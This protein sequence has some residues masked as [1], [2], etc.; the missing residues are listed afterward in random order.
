MMLMELI[1]ISMELTRLIK[2]N[3]LIK[4]G[5]AA[6]TREKIVAAAATDF[7][8]IVDKSKDCKSAWRLP[9]SS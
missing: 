1:S 8:C 3:N 7:I 4:G 2:T 5:G 6:H 9:S